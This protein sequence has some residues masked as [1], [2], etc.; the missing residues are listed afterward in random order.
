MTDLLL[1][2]ENKYPK[3]YGYFIDYYFNQ[4]DNRDL[5]LETLSFEMGLGV[6]LSFFTQ[7]NNYFKLDGIISQFIPFVF[8]YGDKLTIKEEYKENQT[9]ILDTDEDTIILDIN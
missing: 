7:I 1:V 4:F 6:F 9:V 8:G 5:K 3:S 2:L